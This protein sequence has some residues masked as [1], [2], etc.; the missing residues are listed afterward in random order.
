MGLP[1]LH[2]ASTS[3]TCC[4]ALAFVDGSFWDLNKYTTGQ[5]IAGSATSKDP[6]HPK[7]LDLDPAR[8]EELAT[9]SC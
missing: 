6:K 9:I 5:D 7:D 3:F 8:V 1:F 2:V 4:V